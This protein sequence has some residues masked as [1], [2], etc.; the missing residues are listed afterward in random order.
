MNKQRKWLLIGLALLVAGGGAAAVAVRAAKS[1]QSAKKETP[2]LEFTARDLVQLAPRKLEVELSF[3]GNV[4][5][6]SQ[7]TVRSKLSAE[8]KRVLVRE[9]DRVGAGQIVAEFDTSQLRAQLAEKMATLESA[10]AQLVQSQRTHEANAQ[11]IRQNFISQNAMD[12]A[13]AALRAQDAAVDAA[14]AQ[15]EQ[16]Q[17]QLADAV[18]RAPIAGQVARRLVQPGEKVAFD[19]ALLTIVDL[20]ELEV[21]AQAPVSDV[22]Q[23]AHGAQVD[24]EIEG[25]AGR[26]F[27]GRVDRINPAAEA[28]SR[29][30]HVYVRLPNERTDQD[31]LLRAGMFA[32]VHM[33]VGADREVPALPLSAIRSD[34]GQPSVWILADGKLMRRAVELGRRDE[35]AQQ[36]EIV[37]GVAPTDRVLATKF[38]NLRDGLAARVVTGSVDAK[39][40]DKDAPRAPASN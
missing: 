32:R 36:V 3:P 2:P 4:Q 37:G 20:S 40:A 26:N 29:T 34:T 15:L 7:A 16:T 8:V 39:V 6:V 22:A 21:Q 23:I 33:H 30:I 31:W 11:L 24:I 28:G 13:D 12:T 18:V 14:R 5:A 9:G 25:L 1:E 35:R 17:L 27:T 38:D 19:A 10:R